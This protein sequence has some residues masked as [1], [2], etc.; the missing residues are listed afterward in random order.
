[1]C[2]SRSKSTSGQLLI[3]C[4]RAAVTR[5]TL[6]RV[7]RH[8]PAGEGLCVGSVITLIHSPMQRIT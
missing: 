6:F 3:P 8:P 2:C 4:L 5:S 1:M 7:Q